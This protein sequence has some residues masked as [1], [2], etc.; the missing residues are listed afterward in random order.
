MAVHAG[1]AA[2]VLF[3]CLAQQQATPSQLAQTHEDAGERSLQAGR[4][5]EA[6][7]EFLRALAADPSRGE[8]LLEL[9]KLHIR[10]GA[11][12][13][14]EENLQA[15]LQTH[16]HSPLA[17]GLAGEV[18]FRERDL[19]GAERYL[20]EV[21]K[22]KPDDGIAH[23][24]LALCYGA[25]DQWDRARPHLDQAVALSP[26]DEEAHYWRGRCLL[27]EAHYDDAIDEFKE[28]LRL[29]PDFLKAY[30]NLGLCFDRLAKFGLAIK[31]YRQAIEIDRRLGSRY[32]WPYINLASL[33]NHLRRYDETVALLEPLASEHPNSA[34]LFYHLGRARLG[35]KQ[36]DLAE[37]SLQRSAHLDSSLALPHYQ[38]GQLYKQ[39]GKPGKG[40]EELE[41]FSRLAEPSEGN[42]TLY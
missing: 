31:N 30:D 5:E 11:F 40:R 18:K 3:P 2:A 41:I 38:L 22:I 15:Y 42:R 26:G 29:Q 24:L 35:L 25:L 36:F 34:P 9:A 7:R 1:L 12:K 37:A 8:I 23:K 14:S 19:S 27:E 20:L 21:L 10:K 32:E 39:V 6:E 28:T 16:P 4:L 17:L 13:E 33:L